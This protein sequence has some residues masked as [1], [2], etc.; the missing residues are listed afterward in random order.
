MQTVSVKDKDGKPVEGL[1][2]QDFVV[3]ED[4]QPQ[5]IAFVEFQRLATEAAPALQAD[6]APAAAAPRRAGGARSRASVTQPQFAPPAAG[7]HQVPRTSA[8]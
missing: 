6:A 8:C 1:T 5:D 3:T 7:R 2:A 4:G